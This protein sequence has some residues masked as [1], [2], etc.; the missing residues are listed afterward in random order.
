MNFLACSSL[1][2]PR[3]M[4]FSYDQCNE[5]IRAVLM[6]YTLVLCM[7]DSSN[8][9]RLFFLQLP[10]VTCL[11]YA[12]SVH[13]VH[14]KNLVEG[15]DKWGTPCSV[16]NFGGWWVRGTFWLHLKGNGTPNFKWGITKSF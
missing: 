14:R 5:M 15:G 8:H 11:A 6:I 10:V 1:C 12:K 4:L 13:H 2:D 9:S 16:E 7:F 3:F